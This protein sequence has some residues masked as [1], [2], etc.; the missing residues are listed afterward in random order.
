MRT[1]LTNMSLIFFFSPAVLN[2]GVQE[3]QVRLAIADLLPLLMVQIVD[4]GMY[5][6]FQLIISSY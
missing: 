4:H 2:C 5:V 3:Q 6:H 1:Q